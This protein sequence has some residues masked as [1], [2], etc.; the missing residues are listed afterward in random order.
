MYCVRCGTELPETAS[1][2]MQ[3]GA[4][5]DRVRAVPAEPLLRSATDRKIAGICG[6]LAKY[7]AMDPTVVRVLWLLLTFGLPPAGI[8]GYIA[9]WILVP[10]E[11]LAVYIAPQ[12]H[13]GTV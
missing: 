5:T 12:P 10:Q 4:A 7:L 11:P 8:L 3:C 13:N 6:G 2:C 1:Y 9:A